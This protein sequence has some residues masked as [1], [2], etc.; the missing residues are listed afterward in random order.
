MSSRVQTSAGLPDSDISSWGEDPLT[1][2]TRLCLVFLQQVFKSAPDGHYRWDEDEDLTQIIIQDEAPI[3]AEVVNKRPAIVSVLSGIQWAGIGLDQIRDLDLRTGAR[4]HTD[5]ISGN[6]TF[7][8]LSRVKAVARQLGWLV[9]RHFWI[10]RRTL[11]LA[12]LHDIGQRIMTGAV[13]P[14][15]AVISGD[16]KEIRMVSTTVPFHFQWT[17]RISETN[18]HVLREVTAVLNT[19][20]RQ[21]I[22]ATEHELP[23]GFGTALYDVD[24]NKVSFQNIKG[25][26][27]PPSMRGR[28][29]VTE[30]ARPGSNSEP[31][32]ITV[33][34]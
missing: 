32:S 28:V 11:L 31:T 27:R 20:P 15:G 25:N 29:L 6:I 16:A 5:M 9:G 2:V 34:T 3:D 12:G 23:G 7:N 30:P 4:V 22:R 14:P 10:L 19:I 18:L 13:S 26:I 1:H 33:K 17:E 21:V 24:G 8:C